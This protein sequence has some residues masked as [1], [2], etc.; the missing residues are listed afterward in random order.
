MLIGFEQPPL[1]RQ[2][3]DRYISSV[4]NLSFFTTHFLLSSPLCVKG[5]ARYKRLRTESS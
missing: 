5:K 4:D 2:E 1:K 3:G